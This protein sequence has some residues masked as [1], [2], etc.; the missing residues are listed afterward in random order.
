[1][2]QINKS[3]RP[4]HRSNLQSRQPASFT[5]G[6]ATIAAAPLEPGL[7]LVAT[8]IGNLE[9]ISLRG[10]R[11]LAG[12]D[13]LYCEDTRV[14]RKLLGRYSI[15]RRLA[16]YHEHNAPARLPKIIEQI[17]AGKAVA[18]VSDAGTPLV[19]DP[20]FK[21]V[22]ALRAAGLMVTAIPGA[23]AA[24]T[25]ATVSGLPTNSL[26]FAGFLPHKASGVERVVAQVAQIQ[27]TLVFYE[28]PGRVAA[29]LAIMAQVLGDREA[30]VTR[31]LT[32]LYEEVARG[33]LGA[34]AKRF[35]EAPPRGEITLVVA[36][37]ADRPEPTN[38]TIDDLLKAAL[39]TLSVRD[40]ATIVAAQTGVSKRVAY[41][42]ALVLAKAAP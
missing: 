9:D 21:L 33:T 20:G 7:Y 40:A 17:E 32:K 3:R 5:L 11:V 18:L 35:A 26:Y 16:T 13:V 14:T 36:G 31:E 25:A 24:V 34:L 19:S 38:Q 10:L 6:G 29:T 41:A 4:V 15:A 42:R 39:G 30:A 8:P 27:A 22:R 37:A 1:M 23:C 2:T 28:G 12:A